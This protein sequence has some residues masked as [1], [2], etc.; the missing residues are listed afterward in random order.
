MA[1]RKRVSVDELIWL[2]HEA[3][4]ARVGPTR[5]LAFSVGREIGP[6]WAIRLPAGGRPLHPNVAQA[7]KE[8]E[9][10]FQTKYAIPLNHLRFPVE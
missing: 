3:V 1:R 4:V 6:G 10:E 2:I 8:V 7:L 5:Q 9:R